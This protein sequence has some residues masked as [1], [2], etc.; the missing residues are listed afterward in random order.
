VV[1]LLLTDINAVAGVFSVDVPVDGTV[2][3]V[4]TFPVV[5]GV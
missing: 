4:F 1:Y 2:P 3:V 5:P